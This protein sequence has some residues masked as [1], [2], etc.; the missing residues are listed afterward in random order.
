MFFLRTIMVRQD[1]IAHLI[2]GFRSTGLEPIF[3]SEPLIDLFVRIILSKGEKDELRDNAF[4]KLKNQFIDW[5]N[6]L[7]SNKSK[8]KKLIKISG[9]SD[10]KTNCIIEFLKWVKAN[11]QD[12][13]LRPILLWENN[14][15]FSELTS[16]HGIDIKTIS[17]F[18]CFGLKGNSFPVDVHVHRIL[19]RI[20]ISLNFKSPE[21]V[22]KIVNPFIPVGKEFFLYAHIVNHG[23]VVCKS[24]NPKCNVCMFNQHCDF[25]QKKNEW[26]EN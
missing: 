7:S 23:K 25:F 14:K 11:F 4:N 13:D 26:S 19:T 12:F 21:K 2:T 16:I 24:L 6:I 9:L 3:P 17:T 5:E 22:F 10:E 18:I 8:L 20:G 15:I 1:K